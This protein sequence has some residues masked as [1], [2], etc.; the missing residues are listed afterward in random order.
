[1]CGGPKELEALHADLIATYHPVNPQEMFA[2]E[3]MAMA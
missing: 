2:I 3:R 1:M